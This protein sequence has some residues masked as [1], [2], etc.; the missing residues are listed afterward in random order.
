MFDYEAALTR[1]NDTALRRCEEN[2]LDPDAYYGDEEE[3][4]EEDEAD[5]PG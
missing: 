5:D 3:N 4:S 1:L 2:F